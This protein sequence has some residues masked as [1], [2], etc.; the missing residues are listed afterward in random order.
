MLVK[1]GARFEVLDQAAKL[2]ARARGEST[3]DN[4]LRQNVQHAM[5]NSCS[6]VTWSC[7][8]V[9]LDDCEDAI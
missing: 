5:L 1:S 9:A 6:E 3:H 2:H 7:P 8:K 4:Q